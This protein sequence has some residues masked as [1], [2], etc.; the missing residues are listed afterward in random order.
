VLVCTVEATEV[1]AVA[2]ARAGH[3]KRHGFGARLHGGAAR[4]GRHADYRHASHFRNA[5]HLRLLVLG[6]T[7]F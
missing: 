5:L 7:N 4:Q 3:K 1:A 2:R 6:S